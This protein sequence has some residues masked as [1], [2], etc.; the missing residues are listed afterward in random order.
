M[1]ARAQTV[2]EEIANSV[3]H[4]IG[5]LASLAAVPFLIETTARHGGTANKVGATVFSA[6][7]VLLYFASCIYHAVPWQRVKAI[8][9]RL[10]HGAIFLL[11]AGTYT[12]FTLGVLNGPLGWTLVAIVWTLALVGVV[13]KALDRLS[14]PVASL[15]AYIVL[16]S[17]IVIAIGPLIERVPA[18]GLLLI[19]AGGL[20]YVAGVGFFA[21]A[22]RVRYGHFVWHLFVVSGTACHFFAVLWYAAAPGSA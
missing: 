19:A 4:G 1:D 20:A 13:L 9:R 22:S 2:G 5:L 12:P 11:I 15:A 3:S 21:T 8:C 7:I 16:G 10:D 17:L 14:H 18:P 6:T